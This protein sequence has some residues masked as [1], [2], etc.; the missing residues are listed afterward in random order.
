VD[1]CDVT[2]EGCLVVDPYSSHVSSFVSFHPLSDRVG[3][4]CDDFVL[5]V[6]CDSA[7]EDCLVPDS[8]S[9]QVSVFQVAAGS[10][11]DADAE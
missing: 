8:Y 7:T 2:V 11:A 3:E 10:I 1:L 4:R 9:S 6:L 5:V